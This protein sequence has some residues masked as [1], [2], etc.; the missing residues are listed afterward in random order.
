MDSVARHA[1][2]REWLIG[3]VTRSTETTAMRQEA[4]T[5]LLTLTEADA[6][7]AA[8]FGVM[9]WYR[10]EVPRS[11]ADA[12]FRESVVRHYLVAHAIR[13]TSLSDV[14]SLGIVIEIY[15]GGWET[16]LKDYSTMGPVFDLQPDRMAQERAKQLLTV[17]ETRFRTE[18]ERAAFR[19]EYTAGAKG[20]YSSSR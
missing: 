1:E 10:L 7:R 5:P 17:A 18:A 11:E 4:L 9:K 14:V 13:N 12:E 2:V 15:G 3:I 20:A 8:F 19:A 16:F 6:A